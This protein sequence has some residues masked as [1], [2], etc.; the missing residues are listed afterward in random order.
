[1]NNLYLVIEGKKTPPH[2]S[3]I[4]K[5]YNV[6]DTIETGDSPLDQE[7]VEELATAFYESAS[8]EMRWIARPL[9]GS[10]QGRKKPDLSKIPKLMFGISFNG[11]LYNVHSCGGAFEMK[12]FLSH[13]PKGCV[14]AAL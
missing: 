5:K 10:L 11:H 2:G 7:R 13:H 14:V 12:L 8:G 6:I 4:E 3:P 1:M 9:H